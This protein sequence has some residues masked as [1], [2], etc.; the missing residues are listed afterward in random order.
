VETAAQS[1]AQARC[2]QLEQDLA[3]LK[4]SREELDGK[5]VQEQQVTTELRA[6]LKELE[7]QS[8]TDEGPGGAQIAELER[9]VQQGVAALTRATA[10]LAK[11]R[12]ERQRSEQR[13]VTLNARLQQLHEELGRTLQS[14]RGDLERIGTLEEELR[15]TEQTLAGRTADLEQQQAE[16]IVA[17]EQLRKTKELNAQLRKNLSFFEEANKTFG[18]TQ[19]DLTAKLETT[20][21]AAREREANL[22]REDVEGQRRADTQ[23]EVQRELQDQSRKRETLEKELEA[24][25]DALRA[26]ETKLQK[27]T[28]ERQRLHE[29]L[30][31]SQLSLRDRSERSELEITKLQS[32]LHLEQVERQR[33]E[34]QLA[35]MRHAS[36]DGVRAARALRNSLRRRVREP[37]DNLYQSAESLLELEMNEQ[38]KKLAEAILRDALLVHTRLR[39]PEKPQGD[40]AETEESHN[41]TEV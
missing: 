5:L 21:N 24:T 29:A 27:E 2:A 13:T 17:E 41:T 8:Q 25:R 6:K 35:R 9:Q 14:H 3:E 11:E 20:L 1:E 22:H 39:E 38:Q 36:V 12:G 15:Q 31:S 7:Q 10:D 23:E 18:R 19:Q 4:K 26:Y 34:A 32:A 40:S 33:Q 28:A 30:E 16:R 37:I